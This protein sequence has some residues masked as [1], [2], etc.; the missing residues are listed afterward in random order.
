LLL[1]VPLR[2]GKISYTDYPAYESDYPGYDQSKYLDNVL[3]VGYALRATLG[4]DVSDQHFPKP[5]A[6]NYKYDNSKEY[7]Y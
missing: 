3:S 7:R 1:Q 4:F 6:S 5:K 2:N